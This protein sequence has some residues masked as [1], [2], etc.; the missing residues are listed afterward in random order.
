[1]P[2]KIDVGALLIEKQSQMPEAIGLVSEHYSGAWSLIEAVDASAFDGK[3]RAAGWNFFFMAAEVKVTFFGTL[4]AENI[5]KA[6]QRILGKVRPQH[7]NG[8]EI[9]GMVA[10]RFLGVPYA[11]VSTHS[12][13]LQPSCQ[14]D[15]IE[16]RREQSQ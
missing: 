7:F 6:L 15:D 5:L 8:L 14:L 2:S 13:H 16:L 10:R 12:R 11:T 4:K 1:V 3:I 9:T